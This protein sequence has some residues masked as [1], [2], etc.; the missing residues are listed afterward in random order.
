[1]LCVR[2]GLKYLY[3]FEHSLNSCCEATLELHPGDTKL[4]L[5]DSHP[6]PCSQLNNSMQINTEFVTPE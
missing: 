2:E 5:C 3:S 6:V 1:M 4:L